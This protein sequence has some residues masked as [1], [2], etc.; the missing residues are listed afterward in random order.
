MLLA[1]TRASLPALERFEDCWQPDPRMVV[2]YSRRRDRLRVHPGAMTDPVRFLDAAAMTAEAADDVL[3]DEIGFGIGD[4]LEVT[5]RHMDAITMRLAP[6]WPADAGER[7]R[8]APE[9]E[10]LDAR[11]ERI[12]NSPVVLS[13]AELSVAET[14]VGDQPRWLAQCESPNRAGA[15]LDWLTQSAHRMR[16]NVGSD[17][18]TLGA[19]LAVAIPEG[20]VLVPAALALQAAAAAIARLAAVAARLDRN[21]HRQLAAL[22]RLRATDLLGAGEVD[23][24]PTSSVPYRARAQSVVV[25]RAPR[26]AVVAEIVAAATSRALQRELKRSTARLERVGSQQL[27]RTVP[28]AADAELIRLVIY[29]GPVQVEF[30]GRGRVLK[31]HLM[32]FDAIVADAVAREELA[33]I[34][35]FFEDLTGDPPPLL[36]TGDI[37]DAW[38]HWQQ[39]GAFD[40]LLSG[41]PVVIDPTPDET[42]W[43]D[44]ARWEDVEAV[45]QESGLGG[46]ATWSRAAMERP[47]ITT[48]RRGT[49]ICLASVEPPVAL[50]PSESQAL[51]SLGLDPSLPVLIASGIRGLLTERPELTS[52]A[53]RA[54]RVV[55]GAIEI[56]SAA[57][58][59]DQLSDDAIPIGVALDA[60]KAL[61]RLNLGLE[62][63]RALI[64]SPADAHAALGAV[65]AHVFLRL[66]LGADS[67]AHTDHDTEAFIDAWC[68]EPPVALL[69]LE[70]GLAPPRREHG[71]ERNRATRSR[72]N[73]ML[74]GQVR[75]A[76]VPPGFYRDAAAVELCREQLTS[77][78]HAAL[79]AAAASWSPDA[80]RP[81]LAAL[82]AAHAH[83]LAGQRQTELA[84]SAPWAAESRAHALEHAANASSTR[85]LE[86]LVE[87]LLAFPPHGLTTPDRLDVATVADL[88]ETVLTI[89]LV[90]AGVTRRLHGAQL[91][92]AP[93]GLVIV[94]PAHDEADGIDLPAYLTASRAHPLRISS[95]APPAEPIEYPPLA[96]GEAPFSAL[97]PED[98]P[99]RL[100]IVDSLLERDIGC[101]MSGFLAVLATAAAL[102]G[103]DAGI[104]TTTSEDLAASAARWSGLARQA[105]DAA[106]RHLTL[107]CEAVV[108]E[109]LPYWETE[110]RENRLMSKPL[111][112]TPDSL[113]VAPAC[114]RAAQEVLGDAFL[115][116]RLP[117][118]K[119]TMSRELVEALAEAR[120]R[121]ARDLERLAQHVASS[122]GLPHL[123]QLEVHAAGKQGVRIPGEIDLLVKDV[124]GRIWVCEVKD[125]GRTVS[126]AAIRARVRDYLGEHV[127]K[128]ERKVAAVKEGSA[129]TQALLG[130]SG[131]ATDVRGVFVTRLVEPAA[132]T[133]PPPALF[134]TIDDFGTLLET[135][136]LPIAG[137]F[138]VG[139]RAADRGTQTHR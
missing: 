134:V 11:V 31:V 119:A 46:R 75:R 126:P 93:S 85:P 76:R 45:L 79:N 7:D 127:R 63:V 121:G 73:A 86:L 18:P 42:P 112:E 47:G 6:T 137:H 122:K 120:R 99:P 51:G 67:L 71:I 107:T 41:L 26:H 82:N 77:C 136:T 114:V 25:V 132:F 3:V 91:G 27:S 101:N 113:L 38:R 88:A 94:T 43:R 81:V 8:A 70:P 97:E 32:E 9:G 68:Q 12:A 72:S 5:L 49:Q 66:G 115:D 92:V 135:Q 2:R 39:Y 109:E 87:W 95:P 33:T 105:I 69:R 36:G 130:L 14:A 35:Q 44:A 30:R 13:D 90:R 106:V 52:E 59:P 133:R 116:G 61:F 125:L 54:G 110:R 58:E 60:T 103:D 55:I 65:L 24:D 10:S 48:L 111:L 84:L 62:W 138:D 1:A 131:E 124:I 56:V 23:A 102:E 108:A 139:D 100:Q 37:L 50:L 78:A 128:L 4:V 53:R 74:A 83:R 89:G 28:L 22:T 15:A 17:G 80:I 34:W 104:A 19:A 20:R 98:L 64:H 57:L 129:A 40:P 16:V 29:G 96:G 118:P 117:W 123:A 21:V